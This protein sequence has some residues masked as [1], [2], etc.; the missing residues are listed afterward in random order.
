MNA[1]QKQYPIVEA[2][3]EFQFD[4]ASPWDMTVPGLLFKE[5]EDDFPNREQKRLINQRVEM[6]AE[7]PRQTVNIIE[8]MQMFSEDRLSLVQVNQHLLTVNRLAPYTKWESLLPNIKTALNAYQKIAKPVGLRRVGLRFI[9]KI[10]IP[11]ESIKMEDYFGFYPHLEAG[12]PQDF[13]SFACSVVI[14]FSEL[15]GFLNLQLRPDL[16]RTDVPVTI[17]DLDLFSE[18]VA[19]D[20]AVEWVD[21]AHA[22]LDV[23]FRNAITDKTRALL[24][25]EV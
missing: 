4:P 22:E 17:L 1:Q 15:G 19:L 5:L 2:L 10:Q 18:T 6:V 14:A 9:N 3:V 8:R 20:Q 13:V 7:G 12:L 24:G 11:G 21:K 23:A 25:W 16:E